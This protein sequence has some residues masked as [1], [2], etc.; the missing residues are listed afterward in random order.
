MDYIIDH[1][2][3]EDKKVY[4]NKYGM[5]ELKRGQ[6]VFGRNSL[7]EALGASPQEI[8]TRVKILKNIDFLTTKTTN[9][10]TISTVCN[11]DKYNPTSPTDQPIEKPAINQQST[12]N[13]PQSNEYNELKTTTPL[14]PQ[15]GNGSIL[16]SYQYPDW[17]N[18]KLWSD[19]HRMRS[20]IKKPITT[21]RTIDG[22]LK[23]LKNLMSE[24][25]QDEIIQ[26]AIDHCWQTFYPPTK[27]TGSG[28]RIQDQNLEAAQQFLERNRDE[29]PG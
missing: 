6:F 28:N 16:K 26:K 18:K 22:L 15:R 2:S 5:I 12:S 13:Q 24:F 4:L 20:R 8:R 27:K 9:R 14:T 11:Y 7:A 1:A 10:F 21:E 29:N 19:F 23:N 25:S 3:F 17:L